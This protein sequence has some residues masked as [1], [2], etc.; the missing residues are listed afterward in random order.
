ML[1]TKVV[2]H[3]IFDEMPDLHVTVGLIRS[4]EDLTRVLD[5]CTDDIYDT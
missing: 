4:R 3:L 2:F 1:Q 5:D